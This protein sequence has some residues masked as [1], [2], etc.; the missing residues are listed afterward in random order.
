MEKNRVLNQSLTHSPSLFDVPG[1]EALTSEQQLKSTTNN[2]SLKLKLALT[3][4]NN[5][6]FIAG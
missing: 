3:S 2:V 5:M 6:T 1:T 4:K